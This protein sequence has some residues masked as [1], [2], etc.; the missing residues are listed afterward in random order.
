MCYNYDKLL[1]WLFVVL[2][3]GS[4]W[5]GYSWCGVVEKNI[6]KVYLLWNIF[7]VLSYVNL[8]GCEK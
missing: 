2:V 6:I 7:Y 8:I 1:L 3:V 4:N 5:F